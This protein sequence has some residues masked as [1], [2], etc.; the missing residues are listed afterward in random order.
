[1]Y[2]YGI[3]E[4]CNGLVDFVAGEG[5][6]ETDPD[7]CCLGADCDVGNDIML[8]DGGDVRRALA[9]DRLLTLGGEAAVAA[10]MGTTL[11]TVRVII[12]IPWCNGTNSFPCLSGLLVY[13]SVSSP[14]VLFLFI[15]LSPRVIAVI[16]ISPD[17]FVIVFFGNVLKRLRESTRCGTPLGLNFPNMTNR[18]CQDRGVN[19]KDL[20]QST[21]ANPHFPSLICV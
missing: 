17:E 10:R 21:C 2:R 9:T 11:R 1:M 12:L 8:D 7:E 3:V 14:R 13:P 6:T 19:N 16:C 18:T 5:F 15:C 4:T 20:V